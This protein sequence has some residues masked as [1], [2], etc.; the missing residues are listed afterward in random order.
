MAGRISR[1]T[2]VLGGAFAAMG[3]GCGT[4]PFII[5]QLLLNGGKDARVPAEYALKLPPKKSEAKVIVLVWSNSGLHPDLTGV[6]RML[7]AEL[8]QMLDARLKENEEKVLVLKMP[9]IDEYKSE[10]PNWRSVNPMD[11]GKTFG[12]DYVIDVEVQE[13][14]LFKPG[15]RGQ[16]LQ[17]RATVTVEAFDLSKPAIKDPAFKTD[18]TIEF[19]Q[20]RE[21]P[22]ES[23]GQVSEFRLKFVQRL[24]SDI[25]MKFS[26]SPADHRRRFE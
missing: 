11:I 3:I 25:S 15:S 23:R 7:N 21:I 20:G 16:F 1:R 2:V 8:I 26:S 22:V 24:A 10:N 18:F 4:N 9:R 19:P 17:G 6:D 13:M 12:G 5:P 14:D